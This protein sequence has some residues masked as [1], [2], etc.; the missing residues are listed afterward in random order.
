VLHIGKWDVPETL[1]EVVDVSSTALLVIDMQN[2]FVAPDGAL[3][4]SGGN[5]EP[6]RAIIPAL[7]SLAAL[8]RQHDVP[9]IHARLLTLPDGLS[10]SVGS[11]R[12]KLRVNKNYSPDNRT[13]LAYTVKGTWGAE[14]IAESQPEPG[15]VVI[16]KFRSSA[17]C[18]T[19]LDLILRAQRITTVLVT[20]CTTEGC[21][22]A[23]VRDLAARDYMPVVLRDCVASDHLELHT[24]S[25]VVMGGYGADLASSA[26]VRAAWA[27]RAAAEHNRKEHHG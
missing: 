9:V 7:T 11:L 6:L 21:V 23:T 27:P 22:E 4:R 24:A 2:D 16:E 8:C 5:T 10:D 17:L 25:L 18:D 14:F 19:P 20:G 3:A 12:F 15:E 26:E 1:E 13:P